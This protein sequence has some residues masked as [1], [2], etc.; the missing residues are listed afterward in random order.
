M[1]NTPKDT[2]VDVIEAFIKKLGTADNYKGIHV[3]AKDRVGKDAIIE[4]DSKDVVSQ[5]I[6]D[7]IA[8]IKKFGYKDGEKPERKLYFNLSEGKAERKVGHAVRLLKKLAE[9]EGAFGAM[10]ISFSRRKG[11]LS[12][13]DFDIIYARCD[14]DLVMTYSLDKT[15]IKDLANDGLQVKIEKLI[16]DFGRTFE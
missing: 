2:R 16:Q 7:N 5:F 14:D 10:K 1:G 3:F 9:K 4:F 8:E 6:S 15:N 13:D 11:S 12:V